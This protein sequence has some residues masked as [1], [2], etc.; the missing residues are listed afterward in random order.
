MYCD[1]NFRSKRE[2]REAVIR[3]EAVGVY[4]PGSFGAG[5]VTAGEFSVEGPHY[6]RPHRW[7]ARV[8]VTDGRV[9][10]VK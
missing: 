8:R 5:N 3:G 2:L 9:V 10:S 1:I 7:Y 4:Q 6:P